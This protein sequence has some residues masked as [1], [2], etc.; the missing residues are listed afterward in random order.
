MEHLRNFDEYNFDEL[1]VA[2]IGNTLRG[3]ISG[4]N[5]DKSIA[6]CQNLFDFSPIK[7]LRY[8]VA[9][10]GNLRGLLFLRNFSATLKI[11]IDARNYFLSRWPSSKIY[12]QKTSK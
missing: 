12:S 1:M 5:F 9:M 10:L 8:T 2:F 11:K 6:S 4:E 7:V 3:K